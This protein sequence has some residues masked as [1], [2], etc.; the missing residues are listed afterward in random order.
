[1]CD[2]LCVDLSVLHFQD[3]EL[4]LL[5]GQ[6]L[7]VEAELVRFGSAATD[8]DARASGV[9]V[10]SDL[11]TCAL[12]LDPRYAS[13]FHLLVHHLAD[14]HIFFDVIL[15]ELLCVPTR[16]VLSGDTET[17]AVGV[18]LLTHLLRTSLS[19]CLFGFSD[20]GCICR[21]IYWSLCDRLL[22]TL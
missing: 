18:D 9:K 17:E 10:D 1:M 3:V 12:D 7:E 5:A 19:V 8:D 11:L 16:L 14:H 15:V 22:A 2:E 4:D 13:T 20:S 6:L 21:V